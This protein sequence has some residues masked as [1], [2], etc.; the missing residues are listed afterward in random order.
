MTGT[1]RF[2]WALAA[3]AFS[4]VLLGIVATFAEQRPARGSLTGSI[5]HAQTQ[6]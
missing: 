3:A 2:G 4:L 6:G 1:R 5:M